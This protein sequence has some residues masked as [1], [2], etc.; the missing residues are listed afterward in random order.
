MLNAEHKRELRYIVSIDEIQPIP[1]YDRVEYARVNGWWVIVRKD[2][3]QVGDLAVYIEIDAKTPETPTFEFLR[4]R[5]YAVKTLKMCGVISQ[6]LLMS[7]EDFGWDKDYHKIGDFVTEELGITYYVPSDNERKAD[8][9]KN[10]D[11]IMRQRYPN[12]FK[13]DWARWMM[14]REWGRKIMR[15]LFGHKRQTITSKNFPTQFPYIKKTDQERVENMPWVLGSSTPY[16]VTQKC[17]GSSGTFILA[18]TKKLGIFPHYEFYVCSR[19]VRMLSPKQDCFYDKNVYWEVALK[20]NI[21]EKLRDFLDTHPDLSYVCWQ[22]EI[23]APKIQNNPHHLSESHLFLFHMIDSQNGKYD[24]RDAAI[25][26]KHYNME[27]VPIIDTNFFIPEDM[28]T[29]KAMA[30]G[31][32]DPVC[33]EGNKNC[34]REGFVYYN[35]QNPNQSFKNVS[36]KYLLKN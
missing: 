16:I 30:D 20:Y 7:F 11:K 36:K 10:P 32:Y 25:I 29:L 6:G 35:T 2:Q 26:W 12:I 27:I 23:C 31:Y 18:K 24:I 1:N 5:K 28:E 13:Q 9:A 17:D 4:K 8:P 14:K 34:M 22:G 15:V 3:F 21:E 19:N 33:C